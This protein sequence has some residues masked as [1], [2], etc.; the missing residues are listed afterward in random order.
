MRQFLRLLSILTIVTAFFAGKAQGEPGSRV[1]LDVPGID[2]PALNS[3]REAWNPRFF[4]EPK[5][6]DQKRFQLFV[7]ALRDVNGADAFMAGLSSKVG[8]VLSTSIIDQDNTNTFYSSGLVL[9]IPSENIY[10]A[11]WMDMISK[12]FQ[13]D[14]KV[15]PESDYAARLLYAYEKFG[16]ADPQKILQ[17]TKSAPADSMFDQN[18]VLVLTGGSE[19]EPIEVTGTFISVDSMGRSYQN[20]EVDA[21]LAA[22]AESRG[23]P[24]L[25]VG[26]ASGFYAVGVTVTAMDPSGKVLVNATKTEFQNLFHLARERGSKLAGVLTVDAKMLGYFTD[27]A[28]FYTDGKFAGEWENG[29]FTPLQLQL[30]LIF[31]SE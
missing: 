24:L 18:E 16:L 13:K 22:F 25:K 14:G 10:S 6:F 31:L 11:H 1:C 29:K 15:I 21:A 28:T 9:S 4:T 30:P 7:H 2:L 23:L 27:E 19:C 3:K 20:E 5:S 17:Q 8:K 26:P 12:S